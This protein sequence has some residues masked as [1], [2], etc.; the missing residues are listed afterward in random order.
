M[1]SPHSLSSLLLPT[2]SAEALLRQRLEAL[3]TSSPV[4]SLAT[5]VGD[6]TAGALAEL[7]DMPVGNL[8]VGAWQKHRRVRAACEQ[9]R[10][11]PRSRQIVRLM[12]HTV[13]ARQEPTV[14][15]TISGTTHRLLVLVLEVKIQVSGV[16]VVVER[17]HIAAV[18][19]GTA[20]ASATLSAAKVRL[21][22]G[23][24]PTIDLQQLRP[25]R[26]T[27]R[28]PPPRHTNDSDAASADPGTESPLRP[29]PA[30]RATASA[31]PRPTAR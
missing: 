29:G 20:S 28:Q 11:R 22:H 2:R 16:H 30:S 8:A 31:G 17:G 12:A 26:H 19:P 5:D 10:R 9:T 23:S 14:E 18:R 13:T 7:L 21:A 3:L 24:I 25:T 1:T 6:D 27:D 4:A 15:L